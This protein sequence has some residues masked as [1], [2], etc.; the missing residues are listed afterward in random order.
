MWPIVL[1]LL[2]LL[3]WTVHVQHFDVLKQFINKVDLI[4]SH[5]N[6]DQVME[7]QAGFVFLIKTFA[8]IAFR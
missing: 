2:F 1:F 4:W 8:K 7:K 6:E 3:F 5:Q